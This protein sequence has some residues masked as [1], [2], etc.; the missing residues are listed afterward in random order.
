MFPQCLAMFSNIQQV[1]QV[2]GVSMMAMFE[3]L[4]TGEVFEG[5]QTTEHPASSYGRP[6][7]VRDDNGEAFDLV[8]IEMTEG[9]AS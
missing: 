5:H 4:L 9:E 6:V 2:K 3:N 8:G 7:W 1:Y